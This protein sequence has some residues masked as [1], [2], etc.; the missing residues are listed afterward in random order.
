TLYS[1]MR[2]DRIMR[3]FAQ[4]ML[5]GRG[6]AT[7]FPGEAGA[8]VRSRPDLALP[9]IHCHLVETLSLAQTV[10][11]RPA[12]RVPP[13]ALSCDGFSLRLFGVRPQSRGRLSLASP[14]PTIAPRLDQRFFTAQ[15]DLETLVRGAT[16]FRKVVAQPALAAF[17]G[18]EVE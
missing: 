17:R 2:A 12:P 18:A 8:L 4:A 1:L 10:R 14:D 13:T 3:A 7:R 16:L 11:M 15:G 6:P 9:D 5:V